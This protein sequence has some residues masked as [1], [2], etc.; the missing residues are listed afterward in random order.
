MSCPRT[1]PVAASA[2]LLCLAVPTVH[3]AVVTAGNLA[4]IGLCLLTMPSL[5]APDDRDDQL[6]A[7]Y[8]AIGVLC[9]R[10]T[11]ELAE[12]KDAVPPRA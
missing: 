11:A 8:E 4:E 12:L 6:A 7:L 1:P 10:V 5:T 9:A 2:C 3:R